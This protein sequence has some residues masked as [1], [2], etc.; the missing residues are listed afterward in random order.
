MQFKTIKGVLNI[1]PGA[2]WQGI[3]EAALNY[4]VVSTISS[5]NSKQTVSD[6]KTDLRTTKEDI[7]SELK[8]SREVILSD[9]DAAMNTQL[10][11]LKTEIE[12]L[13]KTVI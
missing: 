9:I 3:A 8:D 7:M 11:L 10:E 5:M 1:D 12:S 4:I 13:K 6:V 2:M